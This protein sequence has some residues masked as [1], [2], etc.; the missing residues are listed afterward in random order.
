MN[1]AEYT[2][3]MGATQELAADLGKVLHLATR[4][5]HIKR[6]NLKIRAFMCLQMDRTR[7]RFAV[8]HGE[9]P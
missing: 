2:H 1:L 6:E 5:P 8:R 7:D 3:Q 4:S 9:G